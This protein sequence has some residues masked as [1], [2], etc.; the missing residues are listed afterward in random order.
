MPMCNIR[1][2]ALV[3]YTWAN[4]RIMRMGL[5]MYIMHGQTHAYPMLLLLMYNI[6]GQI[7]VFYT[8]AIPRIIYIGKP[9]HIM[10]MFAHV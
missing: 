1:T 3:F 7:Y 9:M 8:L 10:R 4:P 6:R 2:S 5:P